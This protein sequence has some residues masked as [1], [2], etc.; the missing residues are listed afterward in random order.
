MKAIGALMVW[1]ALVAPSLGAPAAAQPAPPPLPQRIEAATLGRPSFAED[2]TRLDAAPDQ[3]PPPVP[4]R[5]R[6]VF[7]Y[8]GPDAPAN[9]AL[10]AMSL[11]VTRRT[12][13]S[14]LPEIDIGIPP[15]LILY[16][17]FVSTQLLRVASRS[18]SRG[19]YGAFSLGR[20]SE[21]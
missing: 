4:H 1:T 14:T 19:S 8:G 21:A 17:Y 3:P 16:F 5:W 10:S 12:T 9:R 13:G 15:I 7:G 11:A 18:L 6:T 20:I 2:F